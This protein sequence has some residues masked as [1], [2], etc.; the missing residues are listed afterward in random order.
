MPALTD[1]DVSY[2]EEKEK[3]QPIPLLTDSEMSGSENEVGSR[4]NLRHQN[5]K[6][7][8]SNKKILKKRKSRVVPES[9]SES[10]DDCHE[11]A[12]DVTTEDVYSDD[13]HV[14]L[15]S[16]VAN[17]RRREFMN[18]KPMR[19]KS[20]KTPKIRVKPLNSV[21]RDPVM[22]LKLDER[23]LKLKSSK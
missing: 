15:I 5:L 20:K 7:R 23:N 11:T 10:S 22:S 4:N 6:C 16:S 2:V 18:L 1:S 13:D 14:Y 3:Y 21:E 19:T 8:G 12:S 17:L 9:M